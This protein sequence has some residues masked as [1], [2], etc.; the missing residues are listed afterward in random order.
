M[1]GYSIDEAAEVLGVPE[2]R[3]RELVARGVL[4]TSETDDGVRVFLRPPSSPTASPT[5][6]GE[7]R[8]EAAQRAFEASPFR[9]LLS[10]FR[11]LTER[12]G[13]ALLALG[14]SRGEV[15]SLRGR[16]EMLEA[17]MDL[18]L[19]GSV[20]TPVA[21]WHASPTDALLA[22]PPADEADETAS[23]VDETAS[24]AEETASAADVSDAPSQ[25]EAVVSDAPDQAEAVEPDDDEAA[26]TPPPEEVRVEPEIPSLETGESKRARQRRSSSGRF[27]AAGIAEALARAVDP[28]APDLP[29]ARAEEAAQADEATDEAREAGVAATLEPDAPWS[30]SPSAAVADE[31]PIFDDAQASPVPAGYSSDVD[32]PDWM[33]DG[34]YLWLDAA[35]AGEE[36][37]APDHAESLP[38]AVEAERTPEE[39]FPAPEEQLQDAFASA[40]A[41]IPEAAESQ[42]EAA[43]SPEESAVVREES[44]EPQEYAG[45]PE[46]GAQEPRPD[47]QGALSLQPESAEAGSRDI[48]AAEPAAE[49][50]SSEPAAEPAVEETEA[51][52]ERT[53]AVEGRPESTD[54]ISPV[55]AAEPPAA[56]PPAAEPPAAEHIAEP[57]ASVVPETPGEVELMWL[58]SEQEERDYAAELEV[59]PGWRAERAATSHEQTGGK[60]PVALPE[61]GAFVPDDLTRIAAD[62]GWEPG[63]VD[64]IRSFLTTSNAPI[65]PADALLPEAEVEVE[66][67][68]DVEDNAEPEPEPE[69]SVSVSPPESLLW[70]DE[71]RPAF[72][73]PGGDDLQRALTAFGSRPTRRRMLP[74]LKPEAESA[75]EAAPVPTQDPESAPEAAAVRE[76]MAAPEGAMQGPTLATRQPALTPSRQ[77]VTRFPPPTEPR[78]E[79]SRPASDSPANP[80]PHPWTSGEP[81]WLRGRRDPAAR[82]FRRLRRIFPR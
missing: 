10:E 53:T 24:E 12:Y 51:D 49:A 63:E 75:P 40:P 17:R 56:E 64:A 38:D 54:A 37:R 35:E 25:D 15:A 33:A 79:W 61:A 5:H 47:A 66:A 57:R 43:E 2:Q 46:I 26:Q 82:A 52:D 42:E 6:T 4:S 59:A 31:P 77:R 1:N 3:V 11:N 81:E 36:V 30:D 18:R 19:T 71:D 62:Q 22:A 32:E 80:A 20:G 67:E 13:Q 27:A 7:A 8:D 23:E 55:D 68:G 60:P 76:V 50:P 69:A 39:E 44:A 48:A 70:P 58:G 73:M 16:V 28:S 21:E 41:E 45:Q 74:S 34:D 65:E 29:A 9:E 78:G 72:S 14:E